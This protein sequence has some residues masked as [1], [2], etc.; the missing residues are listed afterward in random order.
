MI[1]ADDLGTY[2]HD[3]FWA[4]MDTFKE[5]RMLEDIHNQGGAPWAVWEREDVYSGD[6]LLSIATP[7][8]TQSH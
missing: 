7:Q 1:E 8:V 2:V 6:G 5:K 3:G 4:C